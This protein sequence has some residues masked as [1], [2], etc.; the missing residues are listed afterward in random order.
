MVRPDVPQCLHGDAAR[1]RQVLMSLTGNAVKFTEKG[2]IVVQIELESRHRD[3]AHVHFSV[4]DTGIGIPK[5]KRRV[6]FESFRQADGSST[7]KFGGAGLGLTIS[8][9]LVER[10]GGRIWLESEPGKGSTFHFTVAL[11][12]P[13]LPGASSLATAGAQPLKHLP[14]PAVDEGGMNSLVLQEP[15]CRNSVSEQSGRSSGD[16]RRLQILL[17]EK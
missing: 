3:R 8:S 14:A 13:G 1:L 5:E 7:R 17:A 11:E 15:L 9:Q 12:Q 4:R 2:E 6:V 16:R 10:M